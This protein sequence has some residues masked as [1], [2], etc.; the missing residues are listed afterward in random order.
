MRRVVV[1]DID[2]ESLEDV[3]GPV[4][5]ARGVEYASR[6]AVIAHSWAPSLDSMSG[7]VS[8][9]RGAVYQTSASFMA[10]DAGTMIFREGTCN[11][12]VGHNCKHVV[13]LVLT[14]DMDPDDDRPASPRQPGGPG[15]A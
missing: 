8:G 15:A 12:P 3:I 10:D 7:V 9:S 11:C 1:L 5:F 14:M 4:T 6:G 2:L 13:A